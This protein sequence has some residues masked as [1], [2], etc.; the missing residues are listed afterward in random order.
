MFYFVLSLLLVLAPAVF[1]QQKSERSSISYV[2]AIWLAA[3]EAKEITPSETNILLSQIKNYIEMERFDFNPLPDKLLTEFTAAANEKEKL[4]VKEIAEL[5]SEKF[6]PT[7]LEILEGAMVTRAGELVSPAKKQ[8]FLATKAK[9]LGITLEEIEKVMNSAYIYMP[10]L[11]E[12]EHKVS[13]K[14]VHSY[15][16]KGGIIW[17]H[18]DMS[19][20]VPVIKKK[21]A[22]K[23]SASD[24]DKDKNEAMDATAEAFAHNLQIATRAIDEFKLTAPIA[25]VDNG[26]IRFPLGKKEGIYMDDPYW[27]GEWMLNED[28]VEVFEKS[29]WVRVGEVVDNKTN[30][31]ETSS[32]WAVKKSQWSR[33]M[34]VLEHP[35]YN[36]DIAIKPK[37]FQMKIS[38]GLIPVPAG[39]TQV[40]EEF[41]GFATGLDFDLQVYLAS[42]IG[43]RQTFFI[44][45]GNF[46]FPAIEFE[47]V[48]GLTGWTNTPPFCWGF[49]GGIMKK[50][51]M[52]QMAFSVEAKAGMQ[53]FSVVQKYEP[54]D[55][56]ITISNS[57]IGGQVNAGL[58]YA[59]TPD[60]NVGFSA[61]YRIYPTS[62]IW[63]YTD[64]NDNSG[65]LTSSVFPFPEVDHSG[66]AVGL[67]IHY[68][69]MSM[70][71]DP[72]RQ[73]RKLLN[74]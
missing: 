7:I 5:M 2:N 27:V 63:T 44:M 64:S 57:T 16:L 48:G 4:S 17:F 11:T 65:D 55:Y 18:V 45:G 56:S 28:G 73:V 54:T 72:V 36:V 24:S 69:P 58:D 71:W 59:F 61:G 14:G 33:G 39:F 1:G 31:I 19:S 52:G 51:Y 67:Y 30:P 70:P 66:L 60:I 38:E 29:G 25:E 62:D 68:T 12:Y 22:K 35:R 41:D 6:T 32:G 47:G 49:N 46:A 34:M 42:L 43:V 37:M 10:I 23:T 53:F 3:P 50:M 40:K 26:D 8:S 74:K 15:S 21:V 20:G 9:E 13:K